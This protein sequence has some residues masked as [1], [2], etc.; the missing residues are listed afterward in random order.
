M[1]RFQDG[2]E[3]HLVS[4]SCQCLVG[5]NERGEFCSKQEAEMPTYCHICGK[6]ME[7]GQGDICEVCQENIRAEAM[8]RH[9]K[10]AQEASPE[11]KQIRATKRKQALPGTSSAPPRD[12]EGEKQ[13]HHFKSMAEYL[14]YLKKKK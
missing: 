8:G 14:E 1:L 4:R 9:R 12:D 10:I 13:P 7:E 2:V 3:H 11:K 6:P 5:E